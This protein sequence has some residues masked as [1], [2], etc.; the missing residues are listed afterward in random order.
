[1]NASV[2]IHFLELLVELKSAN[3]ICTKDILHPGAKYFA[4]K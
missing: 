4:E 3:K 1:M 2:F